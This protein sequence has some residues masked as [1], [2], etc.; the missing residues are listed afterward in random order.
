M[1]IGPCMCGDT[2]C[3][4]CGPAQGNWRCPICGAWADDGCEH[5]GEDGEIK[6]EFQAQVA[7]IA[8]QQAQA[9]EDY[10]NAIQEDARLA[11]EWRNSSDSKT[12]V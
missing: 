11:E 3:P 6:P 5:I 9:D 2:Q 1:R 12:E 10:A 4:S 8:R 7:E